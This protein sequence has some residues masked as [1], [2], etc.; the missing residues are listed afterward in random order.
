MG[1]EIKVAIAVPVVDDVRSFWAYDYAGLMAYTVQHRPEVKLSRFM[2]PGSLI[3]RQ[4]QMLAQAAVDTGATHILWWDSDVRVPK[5]ALVRLLD[6]NAEVV[7]ASYT[8][9]TPPY[10]STAFKN[11]RNFDER[12]YV[13]PE[14]TGLERIRAAGFGFVLTRADVFRRMKKPWFMI[15][16]V[17]ETGSHVGEDIYFWTQCAAMGIPVLLDQ[18]LTKEVRH[19]GTFEFG[20]EHALEFK[21]HLE[22]QAEEAKEPDE[23]RDVQEPAG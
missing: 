12:H 2:S 17:P 22:K 21:R 5:D 19:I 9:R 6:H 23:H 13:E 10:R 16:Y 15:G 3:P 1:E 7:L 20:Y 14:M 11:L 18:D 8:E 4:R